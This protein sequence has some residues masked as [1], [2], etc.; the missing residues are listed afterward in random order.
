MSVIS[1][2]KPLNYRL[3][4]DCMETCTV[5]WK[6][7][8]FWLSLCTIIIAVI[9]L[10]QTWEQKKDSERQQRQNVGISLYPLRKEALKKFQRKEYDELFWDMGILFSSQATDLIWNAATYSDKYKAY[11]SD[12]E[13][14]K[15]KLKIEYPELY[16]RYKDILPSIPK[17]DVYNDRWKTFFTESEDYRPNLRD[18]IN[19]NES[20]NSKEL[21]EKIIDTSKRETLYRSKAFFVM[22]DEIKRSVHGE[23]LRS[24]EK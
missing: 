15:E 11:L 9:A 7:W 1:S 6:D 16:E 14:Y 23:E 17:S 19:D 13:Q 10:Y 8:E 4:E 22:K 18:L 21:I 24:K 20:M 5:F 3:M 2:F 12:Y